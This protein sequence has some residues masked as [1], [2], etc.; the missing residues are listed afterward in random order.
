MSRLSEQ[1]LWRDRRGFGLADVMTG[2]TVFGVVGAAI[3]T[4]VISTLNSFGYQ[5]RLMDM[6][7]DVATAMAL[8]QDDLRG[9][10]YVTDNMN[11][12]VFQQLTTGTTSD[13][14]TFVGDVNSDDV[15]ERITY[16]VDAN[17]NL[18]R[19][20]DTWDSIH[21]AWVAGTAQPVAAN[22]T[23]F[24]LRF[25]LV[26]PCTSTISQQTATNVL[27]NQDTTFITIT[28]VGTGTYKGQTLTRTLYSDVAERQGNVRPTCNT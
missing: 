4:V 24:T 25:N 26:D 3:V 10:G 18:N 27:T 6:Q 14:I 22:V 17:Q 16:A 15:S 21:L 11:Q 13:S 20:Q 23:T 19:T 9:A 28:L 2:I 7:L 12:A 1:R 8:V 5:T